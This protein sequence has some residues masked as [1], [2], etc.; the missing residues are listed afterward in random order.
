MSA[1]NAI[2]EPGIK[3]MTLTVNLNQSFAYVIRHGPQQETQKN[4]CIATKPLGI[5][6]R[7]RECTH[8]QTPLFGGSMFLVVA[9]CSIVC[10]CFDYSVGTPT[11]AFDAFLTCFGGRGC[12]I[13]FYAP[14]TSTRTTTRNETPKTCWGRG[15]YKHQGNT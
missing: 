10:V 5:S 1:V 4:D 2:K 14:C 8:T 13:D 11:P 6:S 7:H 12:N 9:R 15:L 3:V